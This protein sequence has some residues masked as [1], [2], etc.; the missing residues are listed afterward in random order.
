MWILNLQLRDYLRIR[1]FE[2]CNRKHYF[3]NGDDYDLRK[4]PEYVDRV[5][6][7]Y[8]EQTDLQ[9][10]TTDDINLSAHCILGLYRVCMKPF[11]YS[12]L[13]H[14][15]ERTTSTLYGRKFLYFRL[16]AIFFLFDK[17]FRNGWL[18]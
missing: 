10:N 1:K 13:P 7:G 16:A 8:C 17:H 5:W 6:R 18:Y 14:P 15:Y 3:C 12:G 9:H 2:S 11:N 4:L